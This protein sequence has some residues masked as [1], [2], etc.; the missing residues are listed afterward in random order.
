MADAPSVEYLNPA[1][2]IRNPAFTQ[3]IAV[4]GAVKTIYIGTQNG[5]DRSG[6][7]VGKGDIAAQTEQTLMNIE[8]C[9]AEAGASV[10]HLVAWSI[11]IKHGEPIEPAFEV[12]QRWWGRRPYPPVNTVL[13]VPDWIIPDLL[14]GIDAIAVVP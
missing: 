6:A 14:I 3:A 4:T 7:V 9:L 10:E 12:F 13:L 2:L 1:T 11:Y 5:V 8:A